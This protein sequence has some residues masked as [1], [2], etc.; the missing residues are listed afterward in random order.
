MML[1]DIEKELESI[2]SELVE[3]LMKIEKLQIKLREEIRKS[4]QVELFLITKR[5]RGKPVS[6]TSYNPTEL[7]DGLYHHPVL[8]DRMIESGYTIEDIK[9][10]FGA[11][12]RIK[13]KITY[14]NQ[15]FTDKEAERLTDLFQLTEEERGKFFWKGLIKTDTQGHKDYTW[16]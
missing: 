5:H 13:A 8:Y 16:N 2:R 10:L 1:N 3:N 15:R 9:R 4:E 11:N 6:I 7:Q 14:G 12:T